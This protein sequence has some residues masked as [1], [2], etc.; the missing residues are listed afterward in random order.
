MLS[1]S[2][3]CATHAGSNNAAARSGLISDSLSNA[4]LAGAITKNGPLSSSSCP[5]PD[6]SMASCNTFNSVS[7]ITMSNTVVAPSVGDRVG[8]LL[9]LTVGAKERLPGPSTAGLV[10]NEVGTVVGVDVP[11]INS[12]DGDTVG[13]V[14]G[15]SVLSIGKLVGAVVS[16]VVGSSV[17]STG[18]KVGT[19]V[20]CKVPSNE[21]SGG[22]GAILGTADSTIKLVVGAVVFSTG[23]TVVGENV[24]SNEVPSELGAKLGTDDSSSET[25]LGVVVSV[26]VGINV[27]SIG[28]EVESIVGES[29]PSNDGVGAKLG[30][31]D[32]SIEVVV[33]VSVVAKVDPVVGCKVMA[34][35]KDVGSSVGTKEGPALGREEGTLVG[36]EGLSSSGSPKAGIRIVS[37]SPKFPDMLPTNNVFW[38]TWACAPTSENPFAEPSVISTS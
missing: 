22:L 28:K 23:D 37:L 2:R 5:S 17:P 36:L 24:S 6:A 27:S 1:K 35:S 11:P 4:S 20:G 31:D 14:V 15:G 38:Y 26:D 16:G 3:K 8:T 9:G 21:V 12:T 34:V 33:G 25:M 10:G 19:V 7:P 32:S 29:V 13:I 30:T 18:K